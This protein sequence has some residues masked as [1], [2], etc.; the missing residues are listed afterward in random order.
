[1]FM[2][3]FLE[4]NKKVSLFDTLITLLHYTRR[5]FGVTWDWNRLRAV[6]HSVMLDAVCVMVFNFRGM[7]YFAVANSSMIYERFIFW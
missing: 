3:P 5:L 2:Q 1:M 6:Y 7:M 4:M